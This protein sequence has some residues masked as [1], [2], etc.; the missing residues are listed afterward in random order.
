MQL[1]VME[2]V[3]TPFPFFWQNRFALADWGLVT[4]WWQVFM[5]AAN[6]KSQM[7]YDKRK[8]SEPDVRNLG[9]DH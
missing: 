3:H 6:Y 8:C 9:H 1:A 4:N 2:Q 7:F 5:A